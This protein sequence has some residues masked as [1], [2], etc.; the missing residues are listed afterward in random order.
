MRQRTGGLRDISA[1]PEELAALDLPVSRVYIVENLQTGLAFEDCP[2]TV[3]FMGLGYGVG[4]LATLPWVMRAQCTY[5]GDVDTHGL[6]ILSRARSKMPHLESALMD[7]HTLLSHRDL[8]VSE[9]QQYAAPELPL[10]TPAE[11]SLYSGLKQQRWGVNVRLEQE[12][13]AWSYAWDVL[14]ALARV[15]L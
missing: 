6:A 15:G 4:M 8:W 11:Q 13:I 5:W 12:R 3:V 7:E 10:L 14:A 2:G 9:D 1:R